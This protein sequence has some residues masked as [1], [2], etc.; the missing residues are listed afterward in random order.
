M[1]LLALLLASLINMQ[2]V[3]AQGIFTPA[4]PNDAPAG[5]T[6]NVPLPPA[7]NPLAFKDKRIAILA[8]HGVQESELTYPYQY[9]KARGAQ[10]DIV[11]PAWTSD[12]ILA[13]SFLRPTLW[14][15]ANETFQ[16]AQSKHYDLIVL[17]G[18]AW[19]STV[20]RKDDE[21]IKLIRQN[22]L[23][24]SLVAA[25]CSGS[26]ILIDADLASGTQLTGTGSIKVDLVNAGAHFHDVPAM[27][28]GRIITGRGPAEILEFMQAISSKL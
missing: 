7:S 27:S 5:L 11:V 24:G 23:A 6:Y 20:V 28:D 10:I 15:T 22:Y 12:R 25:V 13:V 4:D 14:V 16:S 8:S 1:K 26:Q 18:G 3:N 9:L 2:I 21:A 19:N 17:T